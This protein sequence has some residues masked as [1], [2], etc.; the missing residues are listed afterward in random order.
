MRKCVLGFSAECCVASSANFGKLFECV[1]DLSINDKF[2][3][4][5]TI[6]RGKVII[7]STFSCFFDINLVFLFIFSEL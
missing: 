2:Y 5:G 4:F 6:G 1:Q 7:Y 3:F